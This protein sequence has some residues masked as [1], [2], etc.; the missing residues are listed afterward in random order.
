[1]L[2]CGI[3][4]AKPLASRSGNCWAV[5]RVIASKPTTP[6]AA[7][8]FGRA[9]PARS[10]YGA[11]V[12]ESGGCE[13]LIGF[14]TDAGALA[15]DLL[16]EGISGMKIWPFDYIAH[17]PGNWDN[18]RNFRGVFDPAMHQIGGHT[19]SAA[20]LKRGL[21]PFRK[22]REAVGDQMDIMVEGH[23]FWSLPA[24]KKLRVPWKT[25]NPIGWK[26]CSRRRP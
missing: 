18:W 6:V 20:D 1:M 22:I 9:T 26:I 5:R 16:S 11:D 7:R 10:S 12:Y 23:G 13:N 17:S 3:F 2:P 25:I 19:I 24:A 4:S 21:E 14:M 15:Q 8:F